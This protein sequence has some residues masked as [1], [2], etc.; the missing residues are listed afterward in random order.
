MIELFSRMPALPVFRFDWCKMFSR[1]P[2]GTRTRGWRPLHYKVQVSLSW[3]MGISAGRTSPVRTP[4]DRN[5]REP[6]PVN[7]GCFKKSS[8]IVFQ[9]LL[10][11]ECYENIYTSRRTN[12]PRSTPTSKAWRTEENLLPCHESNP[13]LPE[14][15]AIH[16]ETSLLPQLNI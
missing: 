3:P 6:R 15:L 11:G 12:Y 16:S 13:V 8:I 4:W 5:V 7:T 9:M 2:G 10:C 1:T 14:S